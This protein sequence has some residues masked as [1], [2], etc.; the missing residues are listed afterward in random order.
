MTQ[1]KLSI[2]EKIDVLLSNGY[3]MLDILNED[4]LCSLTFADN[5]QR[6]RKNL[7]EFY[8]GQLNQSS[9]NI[10]DELLK[11]DIS[12]TLIQSHTEIFFPFNLLPIDQYQKIKYQ[13]THNITNDVMIRWNEI[14][15]HIIDSTS[16]SS[17]TLYEL[18]SDMRV[19]FLFFPQITSKHNDQFTLI[20][21]IQSSIF[22]PDNEQALNIVSTYQN[23]IPKSEQFDLSSHLMYPSGRMK[24][25]MP[26]LG[27]VHLIEPYDQH[28][29][30]NR[31]KYL[32]HTIDSKYNFKQYTNVRLPIV[33]YQLGMSRGLYCQNTSQTKYGGLFYYYEPDSNYWLLCNQVLVMP[34]KLVAFY[35][36]IVP[37]KPTMSQKF[38]LFLTQNDTNLNLVQ[39]LGKQFQMIDEESLL[40]IAYLFYSVFYEFTDRNG[41]FKVNW[42]YDLTQILD[43]E[44]PDHGYSTF[45][46]FILMIFDRYDFN[47]RLDW[48]YAM[49][50]L[51]DQPLYLLLCEKHIDTIVLSRMSGHNRQV[52]EIFDTRNRS[53]SYHS[54]VLI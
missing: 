54:V 23:K 18:S 3:K 53:I 6:A 32:P 16:R 12:S 20:K 48:F 36:L 51:F 39:Q 17:P 34:N 15:K 4:Q 27:N 11:L 41:S 5:Y 13:I 37:S 19:V 26:F 9:I 8:Q 30:L 43:K 28:I 24:T 45:I 47:N 7:L 33:R 49:E 2:S 14:I 25:T 10:L 22:D 40:R 21:V 52:T 35:H 44:E 31:D 42:K 1:P 29:I 38:R 50:D 46:L